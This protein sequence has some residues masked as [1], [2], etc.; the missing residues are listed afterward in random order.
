M[1]IFKQ[2]KY[3]NTYF[4][5][6]NNALSQSR[7]KTVGTNYQ[8]H[9]IVPKCM[10]GSDELHNL[11][12]LTYKEHR[13]CHRLL[14][15]MTTGQAKHKMMYAYLLFNKHYDTSNMPSP[16][17]YC[18]KDSYQQMTKTRQA[19][20]SYKRGK[21]NIFSSP[22]IIQQVKERMILNNPMKKPEQK[23]RMRLNNNNPYCKSITIDGILFPSIGAASRYFNVT[24]YVL[25]KNYIIE[26]QN[27]A[28]I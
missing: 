4:T 28:V 2:N 17:M 25:K 23:E 27:P 8:T 15:N 21:D 9:H 14:I 11:V 1:S 12:V 3:T 19:N 26:V 5:I 16:Q 13:V 7:I 6:I 24:P 22:A 18:T 20:G 10:G